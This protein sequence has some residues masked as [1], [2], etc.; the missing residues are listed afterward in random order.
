MCM[1]ASGL[2]I[3]IIEDG[4]PTVSANVVNRLPGRHDK[5]R[6]Q[7]LGKVLQDDGAMQKKQSIQSVQSINFLCKKKK[8]TTKGFH[9]FVG[10]GRD[11]DTSLQEKLITTA[12]LI[13]KNY[14]LLC[15]I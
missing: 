8:K 1:S 7:A 9:V 15:F 10:G 12:Y 6:G 4:H 13:S 5:E 2:F 11:E 14:P 3:L